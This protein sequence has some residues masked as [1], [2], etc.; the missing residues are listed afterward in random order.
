MLWRHRRPLAEREMAEEEDKNE[1]PLTQ[2]CGW[3]SSLADWRE[4]VDQ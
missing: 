2:A 3:W 4:A 1:R